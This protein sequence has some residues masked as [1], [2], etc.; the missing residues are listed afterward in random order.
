[1][2]VDVAELVRRIDPT[3]S[4]VRI[5]E[6]GTT[7]TV[8]IAGERVYLFPHTAEHR[9][10]QLYEAELL[11]RIDGRSHLTVPRVLEVIDDPACIVLSYIPGHHLTYEQLRKL[12]DNALRSI[13][14]QLVQFSAELSSYLTPEEVERLEV[15]Y[16][17]ARAAQE[18]QWPGYLALNLRDI[19]LPEK[20]LLEQ[21]AHDQYAQWLRMYQQDTSPR[22]VVHDD[23]HSGNI[24]FDNGQISGILDFGDA[25]TGT[26]TQEL[27]QLYRIDERAVR[28]GI[29]EYATLTGRTLRAED[30]RTWTI[31]QELATYCRW[32]SRGDLTRPSFLRAERNLNVWLPNFTNI[33]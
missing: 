15:T 1:M 16:F 28:Y 24:L 27:R 33:K 30:F 11:R 29:E 9:T 20:P 6:E 7:S 31:T 4:D 22:I 5:I 32:L 12:P 8:G 26:I 17:G 19:S 2:S 25:T 14:R 23:L 18:R 10:V 21:L 3:V 13:I